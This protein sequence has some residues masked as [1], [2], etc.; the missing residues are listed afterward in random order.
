M[1]TRLLLYQE[2]LKEVKSK[3]AQLQGTALDDFED[4]FR[5]TEALGFIDQ[6]ITAVSQTRVRVERFPESATQLEPLK[7]RPAGAT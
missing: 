2:Y 1:Q 4:D 6:A 3:L 7:S 5:V